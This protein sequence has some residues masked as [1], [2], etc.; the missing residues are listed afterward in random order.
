MKLLVKCWCKI[1]CDLALQSLPLLVFP[2]KLVTLERQV[3]IFSCWMIS[4]FTPG[5]FGWRDHFD[6]QNIIKGHVF[7]DLGTRIKSKSSKQLNS[8]ILIFLDPLQKRVNWIFKAIFICSITEHGLAECERIIFNGTMGVGVGVLPLGLDIVWQ[9]GKWE[10]V[11][12]WA[13]GMWLPVLK[14]DEGLRLI[15]FGQSGLIELSFTV[16]KAALKWKRVGAKCPVEH[17]LI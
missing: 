13:G 16:M 9:R 5:L 3:L 4:Q 11:W 6:F 17:S 12:E 10:L 15:E 2:T 1:H 14:S 7:T 8:S